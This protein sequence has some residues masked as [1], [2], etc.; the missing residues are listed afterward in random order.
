MF[1]D[2]AK[3]AVQQIIRFIGEDPSREGL[4]ETPDRVVRAY[5]ELF[6]GYKADLDEILSTT[7]SEGINYTDMIVVKDIPFV[8]HCEHHM[9]PFTGVC[10][11]GYLPKNRVVGLSKLPRVVDAFSKRLQVQERLTEQ[12]ADCVFSRLEPLGVGV[13]VKAS[14][15]CM[16]MRGVRKQGSEMITTSLRGDFLNPVLKTEFYNMINL[17]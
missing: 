14:H 10:H 4:L 6:S 9:L 16:S 7:F 3:S 5:E 13:V 2:N 12:I 11:I 17:G 1:R 8:S 15:S